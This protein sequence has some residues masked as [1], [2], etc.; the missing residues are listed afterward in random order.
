V[1][2]LFQ[3]LRQSRMRAIEA[4]GMPFGLQIIGPRRGEALVLGVAAS[5]ERLLAGDVRTARSVPDIGRLRAS[6][7]IAA[8]EGF[9]DFGWHACAAPSIARQC[10]RFHALFH[11][12]R[13]RIDL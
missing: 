11:L 1:L 4:N 7:A 13:H 5:L 2:N 6:P 3:A 9:R 12:Q 8:M 10:R